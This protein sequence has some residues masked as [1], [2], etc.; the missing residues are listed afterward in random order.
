MKSSIICAARCMVL[1]QAW[2]SAPCGSERPRPCGRSSQQW[3]RSHASSHVAQRG[4]QPTG[5]C[6]H[7][8]LAVFRTS[9]G[10]QHQQRA[11]VG[12]PALVMCPA[13]LAA[14]AVLARYQAQPWRTGGHTLNSWPLPIMASMAVAVVGPTPGKAHELLVLCPFGNLFNRVGRIAQ[15]AYPDDLLQAEQIPN[16]G[17]GPP[18]QIPSEPWPPRRMVAVLSGSID[19]KLR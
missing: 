6:C 16:D 18:W 4:Q 12:I 11:H 7:F 5:W 14:G 1:R 3:P 17:V 13:C 9:A 15:H 10:A 19:A 2:Q 8:V